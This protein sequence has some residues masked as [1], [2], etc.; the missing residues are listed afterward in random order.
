MTRPGSSGK[1]ARLG[2]PLAVLVDQRVAVPGE[3]GG[4]LAG[5]GARV[6]AGRD[7]LRRLR[8]AQQP[9]VVG[10]ADRDVAGGEV[11]EHRGAGE[12]GERARRQRHPEVLADLEV[13]HEAREV[14]RR[15]QQARPER[16]VLAEQPQR[17]RDRLRGRREMPLLVELAVVRQVGL[18]HRAEEAAAVHEHRAVEQP[19]VGLQRQPDRERERQVAARA[20][21]ACAGPR[22]RRRAARPA[23]TG[24]RSSRPT[25][26][27]PGTRPARPARAP[28]GARVRGVAATLKA[29]EAT[30]TRGVRGRHPGVAVAVD[31]LEG[32]RARRAAGRGHAGLWAGTVPAVS[33]C[34]AERQGPSRPALRAASRRPDGRRR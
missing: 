4:G 17:G 28:R 7:A 33:T 20:R 3:V 15:E 1:R 14:A 34:G 19:V 27:A 25:A 9:P 29:G 16:H 5:A 26:R 32:R 6:H 10:L 23:G 31:R 8:G 22:A 13:Q 12:R 21:P 11:R 30:S 18:R 24:P 2:E